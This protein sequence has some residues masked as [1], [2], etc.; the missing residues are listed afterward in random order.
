MPEYPELQ[1]LIDRQQ[2][3]EMLYRYCRSVDRL[4]RPLGYS[5]WHEDG[6][7]DYGDLYC[8]DGPGVIDLICEQHLHALY[9]SHQIANILIDLDGDRA[10]SE[11]YITANLRVKID[12][13]VQ[14]MTIWSRYVDQWS[15]REGRWGIDKRVAIIDFD[16]IRDVTPLSSLESQGSRDRKD[17]SYAVLRDVKPRKS[18]Q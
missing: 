7:A 14:Q 9:H 5:I 13:R 4:D 10:G 2:I 3:T 6:I 16:E 8:G 18:I 1:M 12:E 17:A 11:T 15:R